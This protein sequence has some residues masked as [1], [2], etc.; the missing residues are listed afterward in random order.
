MGTR[1]LYNLI[2]NNPMFSFHPIDYVC[3][4]GIISSNEKLVSVT[5]AF[6][7]DLTGQICADQFEGEFYSGV[8]SQPDFIRGAAYSA[9]GKPII[10]LSST[11]EDGK[12]SRIRPFLLEGEGATI[13]R[14]DVHYVITEYGIAYLFGKTIRERALSLIE[15]A[16]PSFR[17]WL[18]DEAKRLYYVRPDQELKSKI[19]YP[20]EEEQEIVLKNGEKI[21]IRPSKA[22]DI[23][24]LQNIFYNLTPQ[25]VYTRF[26]TRLR[27]LPVSM[28]EHLCNVDYANEMAFVAVAGE[29]EKNFLIGSSCYCVDFSTKLAEIGYMIL[30]EWQG[31]GLGKALQ[32]RLTEYAKLKGLLGFK[33]DILS[34]NIKM[35][36]LA[37]SCSNNVSI[38]ESHGECEVT[39]MF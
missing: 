22:T 21:L 3:D 39:I 27:S 35:R 9:G 31:L 6:A 28:A 2:D 8:S 11:T 1:R 17:T 15:I 4:P 10:C 25:D 7:V 30:P 5:Q 14:S 36:R 33:A 23:R 26:F 38:K 24:G 12:K 34:E 13:P 32:Q 29:R 18:L 19:A 37:Q 20:A 16:H